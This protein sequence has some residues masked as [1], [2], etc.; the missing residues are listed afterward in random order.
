MRKFD[1]KSSIANEKLKHDTYTQN[2]V[3]CKLNSYTFHGK[4][5]R[6]ERGAPASPCLR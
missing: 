2:A 3:A 6:E 1:C 4:V 5:G